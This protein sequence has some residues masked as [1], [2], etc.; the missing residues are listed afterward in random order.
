MFADV[1]P[2]LTAWLA[3]RFPDA[4]AVTELPSDI[5]T[6]LFVQV[7]R[8]GGSDE[9]WIDHPRVDFDCY[10]PTRQAARTFA[11]QVQKAVLSELP[12]YSND[13]GTVLGV[14]TVSGPAWRP[15]DNTNVRR[16]GFTADLDVKPLVRF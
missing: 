11:R 10:G 16:F 13:Q 9:E 5:S 4:R 8:I 12:G 1:E 2:L 6:G 14:G 3:G 15:Y 7:E